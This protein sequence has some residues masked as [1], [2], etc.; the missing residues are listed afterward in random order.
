[1]ED[2]DLGLM[3]RSALSIDDIDQLLMP[4]N[5][6]MSI[7]WVDIAERPDLATLASGICSL[8]CALL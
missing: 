1:M 3:L 5:D 4:A 6:G 2:M 7:I 8:G